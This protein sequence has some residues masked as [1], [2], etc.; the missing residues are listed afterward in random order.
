MGWRRHRTRVNE[1]IRYQQTLGYRE[2]GA[3]LE[4][5]VP[6][7]RD[8]VRVSGIFFEHRLS[9]GGILAIEEGVV[10]HDRWALNLVRSAIL[11]GDG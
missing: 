9:I 5:L 1:L 3:V 7:G 11:L 10:L 8:G 6:L 2:S 4:E